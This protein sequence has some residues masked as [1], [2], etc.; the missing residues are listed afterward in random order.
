[1]RSPTCLTPTAMRPLLVV[2]LLLSSGIL[3]SQTVYLP[4]GG[5]QSYAGPSIPSP[6]AGQVFRLFLPLTP[7]PPGGYPVLVNLDFTGFRVSQMANSITAQ[8]DLLHDALEAGIAVVWAT[9]TVTRGG[10]TG[11]PVTYPGNGV[12]I[13]P[14]AGIPTGYTGSVAP[15]LDV[16]RPMPQKDAIMLVQHLK[17]NAAALGIDRDRMAAFGTSSGAYVWSWCVF[18][19][20]RSDLWTNPQGQEVEDTRLAAA[21]LGG[22]VTWWP[23][24]APT[25]PPATFNVFHFPVAQAG[26]YDQ[27]AV[28]LQDVDPQWLVDTSPLEFGVQPGVLPLNQALPYYAFYAA[29]NNADNYAPPSFNYDAGTETNAHTSW[30]GFAWK[31]MFPQSRLVVEALNVGNG[32]EDDVINPALFEAQAC[33]KLD[34]LVETFGMPTPDVWFDAGVGLAGVNGVPTLTGCGQLKGGDPFAM[35]VSGGPAF[36]GLYLIAGFSQFGGWFYGGTLVPYPDLIRFFPLNADGEFAFSIA[37]PPGFASGSSLYWQGWILDPAAILGVSA[38]NA[39]QSL[40]P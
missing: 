25:N 19:P 29:K 33:D 5:T 13:P 9:C 31:M 4:T 22:G 14:S 1:M 17:W 34:W 24:L 6:H 8:D 37:F 38:T 15:Y 21:I 12:F 32:I 18:G 20:D 10:A 35:G 30:F 7:A 2:L 36:G 11:N 27:P 3:R 39:L 26:A 23:A 28:E 40:I 16:N